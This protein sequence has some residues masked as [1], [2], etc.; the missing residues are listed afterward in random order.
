MTR[1]TTETINRIALLATGDEI[2][3]GDILNTNAQIIA[4]KLFSEGMHVGLHM[5]APDNINEIETCIEYLLKT[6]DALIITGGLGP[7]SDDITRYALSKAINQPLIFNEESWENIIARFKVIGLGSPPEGNRQQALFPKDATILPN[8]VGSAPGCMA[9]SGKKNIFMLPGPPFEC[10]PMV[11]K[12]VLPTLKQNGFKKTLFYDHWLL[13]G[14]SEGHIADQLD[15]IGKPFDCTTGYRLAYPYIE[16]KIYSNHEKDFNAFVSQAE[17]I[18]TPYLISNG[19]Q[20][21]SEML[22]KNLENI[23]FVLAI[24]DTATGGLLENVIETRKTVSHLDFRAEKPDIEIRGLTEFWQQKDTSDTQL[25]IHFSNGTVVK[26]QV[27]LRGRE[28]RVKLY[29]VE[30]ICHAILSETKDLL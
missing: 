8:P 14:V 26:K 10:L 20:T 5:T 13:F 25:E 2:T 9:Q 15:R 24:H 7:T 19:K 17:K 11:D 23:N 6:H 27:P 12:F 21:A 4:Q 29:A 16:F 30:Y 28:S 18:I 22:I 1:E 3:N